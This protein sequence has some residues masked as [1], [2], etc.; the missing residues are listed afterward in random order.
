[1][2][3]TSSTSTALGAFERWVETGE[4]HHLLAAPDSV[5]PPGGTLKR[6]TP[7]ICPAGAST[8]NSEYTTEGGQRKS[9]SS[10]SQRRAAIKA[11]MG[12]GGIESQR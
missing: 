12:T 10:E 7:A 1:M 11:G 5:A 4:L 3:T 9:R 8:K 6:E 2:Q